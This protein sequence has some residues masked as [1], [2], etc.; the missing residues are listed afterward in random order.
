M[1]DPVNDGAFDQPMRR[2]NLQRELQPKEIVGGHG[3]VDALQSQEYVPGLGR[4]ISYGPEHVSWGDGNRL[5]S[6]G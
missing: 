5:C 2:E 3:S 1:P 6:F 4:P